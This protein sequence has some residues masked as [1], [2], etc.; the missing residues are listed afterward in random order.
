[1]N[2]RPFALTDQGAVIA[3]WQ[4]CGLTRA[5]N[6]PQQDIA[7]KLRQQP[8]L[9]LVGTIGGQVVATVMAG[10]DG[11][12]GWINYLAVD[13]LQQRRGFGRALM[14]EVE[15]R[16]AA[17]GCPKLNLQVRA[18]NDPVLAFYE[19]LG[20]RPDAVVSLGKRLIEDR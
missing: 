3:L 8:E 5:W 7:R 17:R 1:M 18:G 12:R 13:P 11:H 15:Q 9:F 14:R 2:I 19:R 10:F 4:G 6:D 16:L 20:Y